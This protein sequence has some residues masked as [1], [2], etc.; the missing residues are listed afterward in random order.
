MTLK[1]QMYQKVIKYHI[2]GKEIASS[3]QR[4]QGFKNQLVTFWVKVNFAF[5]SR[6]F[7]KISEIFEVL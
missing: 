5:Q 6:N 2:V 1:G 3:F 4:Y 7:W